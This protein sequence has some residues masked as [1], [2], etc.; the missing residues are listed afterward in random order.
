MVATV[1]ESPVLITDHVCQL[2]NILAIYRLLV[3]LM[4]CPAVCRLSMLPTNSEV[5]LG[6][7]SSKHA[8]PFR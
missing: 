1:Y 7:L 4:G 8:Q 3:P 6:P 2:W 5:H